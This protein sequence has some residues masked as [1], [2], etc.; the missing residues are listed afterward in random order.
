MPVNEFQQ[1]IGSP[2]DWQPRGLPQRVL[3]QGRTCRLEPLNTQNHA[4]QLYQA[5]AQATD[6]RHW[7]YMAYGPFA[8]FE[9]YE[10]HCAQLASSNDPMH[11][12]VIDTTS[13]AAV[14]SLSLMRI[15]AING[16]IEVGHVMFSPLLQG[17]AMS[18]EAQFLLMQYVFDELGYRRYEWKCDALNE[19]SRKAAQR[20]GFSFEGVFRQAVVYKGRNRDTAWFSLLD[21]EWPAIK[22]AFW[23]WLAP[24]NFDAQGQQIR[25]LKVK[26]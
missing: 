2:V 23:R 25:P 9:D 13:G 17:S 1:P 10:K 19:P 12:A 5:Y 8:N 18:T 3:L 20:L 7:T 15:D 22:S 11:W 26:P 24:D 6:S 4:R 14:G 16:V 21:S